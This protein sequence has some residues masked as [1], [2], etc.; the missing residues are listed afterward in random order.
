MV[1]LFSDTCTARAILAIWQNGGRGVEE[2]GKTCSERTGK[3]WKTE[4]KGQEVEYLYVRKQTWEH[5]LEER[6]RQEESPSPTALYSSPQQSTL[7]QRPHSSS[8]LESLLRTCV[9]V[10][11]CVRAR[12][13]VCFV[14]SEPEWRGNVIRNPRA[15]TKFECLPKSD[16]RPRN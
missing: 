7:C 14:E 11:V 16:L 1:S 10:C 3:S 8:H 5:Y 4:G 13:R 6:E 15:F 9:C 2:N 12:V